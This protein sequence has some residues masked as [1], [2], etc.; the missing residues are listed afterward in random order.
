MYPDT[1]ARICFEG[2]S[3]RAASCPVG[4]N[5]EAVQPIALLVTSPS[6]VGGLGFSR[7]DASD[8][9]NPAV[10]Y[11]IGHTGSAIVETGECGSRRWGGSD[12]CS[13]E[14]AKRLVA[15]QGRAGRRQVESSHG[16]VGADVRLLLAARDAWMRSTQATGSRSTWCSHIRTT[17]HPRR[18]SRRKFLASLR[19]VFSIFSRQKGVSEGLHKGNRHPCQK[20]PSTKTAI[21]APGKTRSGFPGRSP[22]CL[23]YLSPR[24]CAILRMANSGAVS[25]PLI[26]DIV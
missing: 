4:L 7:S 16:Y 24:W 10:P 20:S 5:A 14:S 13:G 26:R 11:H 21:F 8:R 15:D 3:Q 12:S 25:L 22:A 17:H 23:R 2:E 19:R 9:P 18:R 6:T 1:S